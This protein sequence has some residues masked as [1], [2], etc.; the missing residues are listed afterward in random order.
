MID[1]EITDAKYATLVAPFDA[2]MPTG[3]TANNAT[4]NGTTIELTP[5]SGAVPAH[6]PVILSADAATTF[7]ISGY[8]TAAPAELKNGILTGTYE[9]IDAP[10]GSCV[11][12]N[13]SGKVGFYLVTNA[14]TPKVKANRAYLTTSSSAKAFFFDEETAIENVTVNAPADAVIYNVAGQRLN[15]AQKGVNIINGKKVLK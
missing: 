14:A 7:S 5:I 11:L 15:K 1:V 2:V 4:I 12:Q 6:T 8:P 13:Q 3:V 10:L 9:D